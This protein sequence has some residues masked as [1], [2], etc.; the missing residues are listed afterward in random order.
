MPSPYS[1]RRRDKEISQGKT[2]ILRSVAA[3]FTN[4][5]VRMTIGLPRPWP[6]YPTAPASYPVSVRQLRA[7][8]PA[9]SPPRLA[10]TQ[11]PSAISSRHQGL[12][13]TSTSN[14]NAMP[15][16]P[17]KGAGEVISGAKTNR[18]ITRYDFSRC[19]SRPYKTPGRS[20][21]R[22]TASGQI[23]RHRCWWPDRSGSTHQPTP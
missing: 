15:G 7:L 8:L 11:L 12:K 17:K 2:L 20:C 9:S 13:R 19:T 10:T 5:R 18:T 1:D 4:A 22:N 21:D 3:G 6:S 23:R 14:I 16:T